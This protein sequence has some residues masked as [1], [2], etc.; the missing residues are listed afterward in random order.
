MMRDLGSDGAE[1]SAHPTNLVARRAPLF[2]RDGAVRRLAE[3]FAN[4]ERLVTLTGPAGI[5]KT[6][7]ALKYAELHLE[8]VGPEGGC[9]VCDFDSATSPDSVVATVAGVLGVSLP[10]GTTSI[11]MARELGRALARRGETLLVADDAE[12]LLAWAS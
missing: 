4:G 6:T 5:G 8:A 12:Q 10:A 2:G 7:L 3:L 11:Q 9:W 1:D